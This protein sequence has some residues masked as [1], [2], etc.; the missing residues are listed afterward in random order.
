MTTFLKKTAKPL[1]LLPLLVFI[2]TFLGAGIVLDDFYAFPSPVAVLVGI[3]AAFLVHPFTTEQKVATLVA[4]CGDSKIITMCLI[5]LLAGGFAVVSKAMGGVDA[6]VNLGINTIAI[7][8]FPL[9]I[10]LIAAFLSTAT[11]TSVGAIVALGPIAVTLADKSGASLPLI[12]GALLGGSMFGDNLSMISDTTIAATQSLG[13]ALKDKFKMNVFIAFP[14]AVFTVLV[15][16]YLG[17]NSEL[18]PVVIA[19]TSFDWMAIV[20]YVLVVVLALMGINVFLTLL[21]GTILAG[22]IGYFS[23]V[24]TGITFAQKLYEG[25]TGMTDIF[26]LSMLTGGLAAM[27]AKAG[28]IDYLLDQ[29]KKRIKNKKSAQTGIGVLVGCANLAIANNTVSIVITGPIAKQINEE[30]GLNNKKTAAILDIFSCIVQGILPYGAQVLLILSFANGK[31]DFL[32]LISN[33]WYH[34]FLLGCT[35]FAIYSSY[36]DRGAKRFFGI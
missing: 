9:G 14:A 31:I 24:F 12:S 28:G 10:F 35:L 33:A 13:C 3:I 5:Y 36:W 1:A 8:Y 6:V 27:V 32:D 26:L 18:T 2:F 15:L 20:P 23:G 29:I 19:K 30:Y 25:F 4:G 22:I 16:F 11:G 17:W 7:A 34:L 21:T